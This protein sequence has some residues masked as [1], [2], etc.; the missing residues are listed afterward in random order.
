MLPL[1]FR[2]KNEA[3]MARLTKKAVDAAKPSGRDYFHWDDTLPGFG[4][5]VFAS[6]RKSYVIQ[7]RVAGRTRRFT[8]GMHGKLT[9]EQARSRAVR[10]LAEISDG[11]DPSSDRRQ[12]R[13]A[14]TVS[15][16]AD[17]YLSEGP[18]DKP[19][20]KASSWQTDQSNIRRHILPLLGN[21]LLQSLVQ[22]DISRFQSDVA[23]GKTAL[24]EKTGF[25]GRAI[26][27]GGRG[28]AARSLSVLAAMLQFAVRRGYLSSNPARDVRPFRLAKKERFLTEAEVSRLAGSLNQL[29]DEAKVSPEATTAIRLLLLTGCRKNEILSLRWTNVDLD[30]GCL[31]LD[32][33]KTGAR[34]IPLADAA[35]ELLSELPHTSDW[36]LP[37]RRGTGH[38]TGLTKT[39]DR[40]RSHAGLDDV[41]LHDLRHSFASFAVAGGAT[42][43]LVGKVLGHRQSRTTEGYAHL[44]DD[45]VRAVANNA[46]G[47]VSA[48]MSR[49]VYRDSNIL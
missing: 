26:V 22:A 31:H 29:T 40:I 13:N 30:R 8:I 24:D 5:R 21:R 11:H 9:A 19:N 41:R 28:T 4:V 10:L 39:W 42:L 12:A 20:K 7:Y 48:A 46:A 16:L 47:R 34:T 17:L 23:A 25:R 37:S 3:L 15:Q 35:V 27:A 36:V 1:R 38:F 18:A 32:D 43:F 6:G 33:S 49:P 45:P 44:Q 14:I 2:R